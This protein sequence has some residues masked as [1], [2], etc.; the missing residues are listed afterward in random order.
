MFDDFSL[1]ADLSLRPYAEQDLSF[2]EALFASTRDFFDQIPLPK[3]QVEL[4]LKQQFA[5]QQ[6][7]YAASFP[8]AK[9]SIIQLRAEPIGKLVAYQAQDYLHLIDISFIPS[10]R[11]KGYGTAVLSECQ[12]LAR[13]AGIPLKLSV[14]NHNIRAKKLYLSLGFTL[15]EASSTHDTLQWSA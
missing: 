15:V 6:S 4:L 8:L 2:A 3:S 11:G 13:L 10:A 9:T 5:L 14:E 12:R 7:Y 1:P